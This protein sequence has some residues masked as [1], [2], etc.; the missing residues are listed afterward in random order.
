MAGFVFY[1]EIDRNLLNSVKSFIYQW[2]QYLNSPINA[3]LAIKPG[4]SA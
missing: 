3:N 1:V 4:L 2:Y